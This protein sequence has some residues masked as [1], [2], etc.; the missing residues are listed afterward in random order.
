MTSYSRREYLLEL[1]RTQPG[2]RVRELAGAQ[3]FVC[4]LAEDGRCGREGR[5]SPHAAFE[6]QHHV[7]RLSAVH[8]GVRTEGSG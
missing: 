5:A 1:L 4:N 8:P 7:R 6:G 2:M 3:T